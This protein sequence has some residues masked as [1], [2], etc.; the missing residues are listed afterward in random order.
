MEKFSVLKKLA[1]N[2]KLVIYLRCREYSDVS[3]PID[4]VVVIDDP[5]YLKQRKV[6]GQLIAHFRFGRERDEVMGLKFY[7]DFILASQQIYPPTHDGTLTDTQQSIKNNIGKKAD[8][9]YPF[10]FYFPNAAPVS[11]SLFSKEDLDPQKL[12]GVLYFVKIFVAERET[13][14]SY[15]RNSV[16]MNI[17]RIQYA[18]F[19]MI[20]NPPHVIVKQGFV[21][22]YG[23]IEL[24]T[25]LDKLIFQTNEQIPVHISIHNYSNKTV[26]RI[27]VSLFQNVHIQM[28]QN[29][30]YKRIIDEYVTDKGCPV[31]P[32]ANLQTTLFVTSMLI[33]SKMKDGIALDGNHKL[34][35]RH[36]ASST[37][38]HSKPVK[39]AFGFIV[40]Y[41]IRV[42]LDLGTLNGQ[43]SA[44]LPFVLMPMKDEENATTTMQSLFSRS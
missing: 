37:F 44:T 38:V 30:E 24:E 34:E 12:C 25:T 28:L 2:G 3:E 35:E 40:N 16:K 20:M 1:P 9:L 26:K 31:S 32:G 19:A 10:T 13:D 14:Y 29:V 39:D 23:N 7:K 11:V 43:M 36:L 15:R 21:I 18:P 17:R 41:L 22:G 4:G 5:R 27:R 8:Q 6:F 33:Q 42:K